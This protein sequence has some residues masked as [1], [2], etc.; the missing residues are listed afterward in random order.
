MRRTRAVAIAIAF[1]IAAAVGYPAVVLSRGLPRFPGDEPC[2]TRATHSGA[3]VL[4]LA[5]VD[6]ARQATAMLNHAQRVGFSAAEL[7][8]DQCGNL[9]V[10]VP[11]Y[12]DLPGAL[13]AVTEAKG[14]GFPSATLERV[15]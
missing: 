3:I 13:S 4:V 1:A 6:T 15:R 8:T 7:Q 11:G 2:F 14:A 10:V 9:D 5:S 12:S